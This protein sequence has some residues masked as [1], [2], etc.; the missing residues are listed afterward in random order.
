MRLLHVINE[1]GAGGAEA[2]V[3][4]LALG[5]A[6]AG[7]EVAVVSA[8][9]WRETSLRDGG[10]VVLSAP[11]GERSYAATLRGLPA[12]ARARSFRPDVIHG[13]NVRATAAAHL[14]VRHLRRRPPMLTTFHGV[15]EADYPAAASWLDRTTDH[16]VAVSD[17][18]AKR[19]Q[20]AHLASPTSV[21][22]NAI[23]PITV[24]DRE[25]VRRLLDIEPDALVA[26]CVARVVPQKRHDLL[27]R[28][29]ERVP[30][31]PVLICAG[32]GP[33]LAGLEASAARS[34]ADIRVLGERRDVHSL[35]CA[36]D[37]LVLAS[38]WEGLPITVLEG[39]SA[40]LP[41]VATDVDGLREALGEDAGVLV[42]PGDA[43][44]LATALTAMLHDE[45]KRKTLGAAARMR[46]AEHHS[47]SAMLG[48]YDRLYTAVLSTDRRRP[49][50]PAA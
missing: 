2:V 33:L 10:V 1:L 29:W 14:A 32:G 39:M 13:H 21:V 3:E 43:G 30:G 31:R 22:R 36:A 16:V 37:V 8:G 27:V 9:G 19:L 11:M 47:L 34:P 24:R 25:S 4:A 5:Q 40:G 35:L 46:V 41:L 15:A 48:A 38:D 6:A 28:A 49:P 42:P 44:A 26:L 20:G 23:S 45:P 7:H 12:L 17:A 50:A 18:V